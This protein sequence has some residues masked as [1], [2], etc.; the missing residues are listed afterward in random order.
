MGVDEP[1]QFLEC[2]LQLAFHIVSVKINVRIHGLNVHLV[3]TAIQPI[4]FRVI[5]H[6]V[7]DNGFF[8]QFKDSFVI[9]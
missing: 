5:A 8:Q 1:K 2:G 9:L 3:R 4:I 7:F 6:T